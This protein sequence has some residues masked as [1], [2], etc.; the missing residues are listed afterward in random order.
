MLEEGPQLHIACEGVLEEGPPLHALVHSS[1][2]LQLALVSAGTSLIS[3][4]ISAAQ[5]P[6][7]FECTRV[8]VKQP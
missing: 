4:L 2:Q 6:T 7:A 8:E 1:V 3:S 5:C